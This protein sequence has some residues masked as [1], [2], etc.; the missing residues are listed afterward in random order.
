MTKRLLVVATAIIALVVASACAKCD[1]CERNSPTTTFDLV[2]ADGTVVFSTDVCSRADCRFERRIILSGRAAD[3]SRA[4]GMRFEVVDRSEADALGSETAKGAGKNYEQGHRD[5]YAMY[6]TTVWEHPV[7]GSPKKWEEYESSPGFEK[8]LAQLERLNLDNSRG[9]DAKGH[10]AGRD[11]ARAGEEC[12]YLSPEAKA[13]VAYTLK[14]MNNNL[15][16]AEALAA[17]SESHALTNYQAVLH[18]LHD[19][20]PNIFDHQ[21]TFPGLSP[22]SRGY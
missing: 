14:E 12:N 21:A 11:A 9:W 15:R 2:G 19:E 7:L 10:R 4:R 22:S 1:S 17:M 20:L 8:G 13:L 3:E 5:G 16:G 6:L 18:V